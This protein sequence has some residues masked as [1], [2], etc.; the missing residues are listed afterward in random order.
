MALTLTARQAEILEQI[1]RL[2]EAN[3]CPPS[4]RE[5][6]DICGLGGPSGAHRM[7]ST[8]ERKGF[9]ERAHGQSRGLVVTQ[10]PV[11]CSVLD[12]GDVIRLLTIV[13]LHA[14]FSDLALT[15]SV[16]LR[17]LSVRTTLIGD[18]LRRN[19]RMNGLSEMFERQLD[20]L[21]DVG[22]HLTT[23]RELVLSPTTDRWRDF[24]VDQCVYN[25][26]F[27]S[28]CDPIVDQDVMRRA[29]LWPDINIGRST[30]TVTETWLR[31]ELENN[32]AAYPACRSRAEELADGV[33]S[34]LTS[35]TRAYGDGEF[36]V[37]FVP[38]QDSL[39]API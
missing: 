39:L 29:V 20:D 31:R 2:T 5:L 33:D 30:A 21:P 13:E 22:V 9:V 10:P 17:D 26:I 36:S 19:R 4:S 32:P 7:I 6:S 1:A 15:M 3:G 27:V 38:D 37:K 35:I 34:M 25:R 18:A 14:V 16:G 8:L 23:L 12:A 24:L 28:L 11:D